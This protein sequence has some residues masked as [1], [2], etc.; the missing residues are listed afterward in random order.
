VPELVGWYW[1]TWGLWYGGVFYDFERDCATFDSEP[2]VKG[3]QWVRDLATALGQQRV[4]R[5][6]SGL[7]N[8]N[9]PDNPFMRGKLAMVQQGPWF[10]NMIRQYASELDY[11]VAPFPTGDGREI[12]Y[13]GQDVMAI[14]VGA[15]NADEAWAFM[16]WMYLASPIRVPSGENEPRFGYEYSL[17][18]GVTGTVRRP[19]PP[20]RPVEWLCWSH[21]KNGPFARPS[22][23]F[24]D[25][26]PNPAIAVHEQLARS[27]YAMT[28]P[29]LPNWTEVHGELMAAY[30]DIWGGTVPVRERLE[31]C[32]ERV[33]VLLA[34]ARERQ[35]RYGVTFP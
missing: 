13:S 26:H 12:S 1:H 31:S 27:R 16:E 17:E 29:P 35:R 30:R 6:E 21:Y 20:L 11:G 14:P 7:G 23:G 32:R 24:V 15:R 3:Y 18:D 19:M 33:D 4:L 2:Y 25:S 10:A 28:E 22:P 5:F 8:F 9:S 34:L